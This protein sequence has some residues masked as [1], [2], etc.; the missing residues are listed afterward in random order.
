MLKIFWMMICENGYEKAEV[1]FL[2]NFCQRET[3]DKT[4]YDTEPGASIVITTN[5]DGLNPTKSDSAHGAKLKRNTPHGARPMLHGAKP[6]S[7]IA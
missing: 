4:S 5:A 2:P 3:F 6:S 1:C 7:K